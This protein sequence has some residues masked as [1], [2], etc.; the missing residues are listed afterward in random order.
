MRAP[1]VAHVIP[2][3][4]VMAIPEARASALIVCIIRRKCS[5]NFSAGLECS[6]ITGNVWNSA[7]G[8]VG[9]PVARAAVMKIVGH[10]RSDI[11]RDA[12]RVVPRHL[13]AIRRG[14]VVAKSVTREKSA[15]V[16]LIGR[17][18]I[19]AVVVIGAVEVP[20]LA[21]IMVNAH[22]TEVARLRQRE[23]SIVSRIIETVTLLQIVRHRHQR[24]QSRTTT[25]R[26]G[27]HTHY[28]IYSQ[29]A[30]VARARSKCG[31]ATDYA[32]RSAGLKAARCHSGGRPRD[33]RARLA[34]GLDASPRIRGVCDPCRWIG[35][36]HIVQVDHFVIEID[37]ANAQGGQRVVAGKDFGEREA[38]TL[39]IPE[40]ECLASEQI[41][42]E[43]R[44]ARGYAK[45]AV[46]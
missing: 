33:R 27:W 6:R 28:G 31:H 4:I 46:V 35:C 13:R 44:T 5:G 42:G 45:S 17:G 23:R 36:G 9:P 15:Y 26:C 16:D 34:S 10:G 40:N 14:L 43:Q 19:E 3:E 12:P 38:K 41:S 11:R 30:R 1:D 20:L 7:V 22:H 39:V 29:V 25:S 21:E 18:A 37:Q 2:K 8:L 32:G 24:P